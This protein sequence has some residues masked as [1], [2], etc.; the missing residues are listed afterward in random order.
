MGISR[1]R[2]AQI[3]EAEKAGL[4]KV[5]TLQ[6]AADALNCD[7]VYAFVP[8]GSYQSI[9]AEQATTKTSPLSRQV[10][11]T[12]LLEGQEPDAQAT[13]RS[14]LRHAEELFESGRLW[15]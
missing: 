11:Q 14:Q 10:A 12:M 2:V 5:E 1:R 3:E 7:L 8:R 15:D 9:V 13:E 6:R 4:I